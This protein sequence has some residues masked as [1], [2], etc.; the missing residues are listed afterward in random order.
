MLS[1]LMRAV[2]LVVPMFAATFSTI[3]LLSPRTPPFLGY[4]FCRSVEDLFGDDLCRLNEEMLFTIADIRG[5]FIVNAFRIIG[6]LITFTVYASVV[7][8]AVLVVLY[9]ALPSILFQYN[10]LRQLRREASRYALP[11][12]LPIV[13]KYRQLQILNIMFN[14]IYSR[15]LFAICMASFLLVAIPGGYFIL[16]TH[17]TSPLVSTAGM[18]ILL[19][20]YITATVMFSMAGKLWSE[21]VECK[22]AWKAND[23]LKRKQIPLKYGKSLQDLKVKIGSC[24]FVEK[25]TPFVFVSFCIE[26]TVN[27]LLMR[28]RT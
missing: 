6:A 4:L 2:I 10:C 5:N 23:Q 19:I 7:S 24:N 15:D 17:S 21:S 27:L 16:V 20:A 13:L 9:E 8:N 14:N 1:F 11:N 26:Q 12:Y 28:E 18:Y 3:A 25:N 22:C